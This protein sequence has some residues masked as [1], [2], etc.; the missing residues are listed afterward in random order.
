MR[1]S[2]C[3]MQKMKASYSIMWHFAF[4]SVNETGVEVH[5]RSLEQVPQPP[6][7]LRYELLKAYQ[8]KCANALLASA[9]RCTFSR[10]VIAAPSRL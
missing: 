7:F 10:L 2:K 1:D 8:A 5:A 9:M 4:N 3:E 6:N